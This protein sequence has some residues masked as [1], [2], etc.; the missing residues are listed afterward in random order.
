MLIALIFFIFLFGLIIGSFLN[1]AIW[2]LHSQESFLGRSRCTICKKMIHWHDNIPI[3]SYLWLCGKCRFCR[4]KI[5][6]Q[7]PLV[8]LAAGI[9]FVLAYLQLSVICHAPF[10]IELIRLWFFIAVLIVI[11]V[12]DLRWYLILDKITVPAMMVA[13]VLNLWLGLSWSNLLLSGIIGGGFFLL[14]YVVSR[15][16]WI[17]GGDIR[18]GALMGLMLGYPLILIALM[19]AYM[20]GGAVAIPLLISGRRQFG[21]KLPF[22]TFLALATVITLLYGERILNWYLTLMQM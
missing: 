8:E 19:L 9:L 17:G 18:L 4:K 13:F 16:R 5:A 12:Y 20:L 22:G 2:R 21:D 1:M 15:G 7:Y 11:F 3:V 10:A 6:I 14:Q